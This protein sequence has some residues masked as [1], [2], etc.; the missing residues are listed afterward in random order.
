MLLSFTCANHKSIRDT[1]TLHLEPVYDRSRPALPLAAI[2][3][4][5][6]AGKSNVLDAFAFMV[7]AVRS[8][9]SRWH[10][11]VPRSP[12]RLDQ[13][14]AAEPSTFA[15]ELLLDG[16]R[17]T[18]G[19][20]V[21]STAVRTEWLHS[22]P[23]QRRR[24]IFERDGRTVTTGSSSGL[25]RGAV[26]ILAEL[27]PP[28]ALFLSVAGRSEIEQVEPV[29]RWFADAV[30][31]RPSGDSWLDERSFVAQLEDPATARRLVRLAAAADVGIVD[32]EVQQL[33]S[34]SA[35]EWLELVKKRTEILGLLHDGQRRLPDQE[36]ARLEREEARLAKAIEAYDIEEAI[37]KR[38]VF[39]H[40]P[41]HIRF[42]LADESHGT[43]AWLAYL[44]PV[45]TAL[46]KGG[47]LVVD[48]IDASLHP[49]LIARLVGMFRDRGANPHGAQLV[50]TTHDATLLGRRD[51]ENII[52]RDEAWFVE[53]D[54]TG[55]TS[56]VA[57]SDFKPRAEENTER[58]YLAG[59][60]GGV[61][62]LFDGELDP[63]E[64]WP[65]RDDRAAS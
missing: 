15:V 11:A 17:W 58:R 49:L 7:D 8:S 21:D 61:P 37:E 52:G 28:T 32:V 65:E 45:L 46:D 26:E 14:A 29:R 48:E 53:K 50:C 10:D 30:D 34:A 2:F 43:R 36:R 12:F 20:D 23:Q 38:L 19:F 57:L 40:S 60:Y 22:Y 63:Q 51:G 24:V 62:I 35:R 27:T 4:A 39:L 18:Y 25:Q 1:Q 56:L 9:F 6:A 59:V 42:S 31:I 16:V 47:V 55:A 64:P 5:N 13:S 33:V 41:G 44:G 3:G 54:R